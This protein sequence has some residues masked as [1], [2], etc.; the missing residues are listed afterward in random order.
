MYNLWL[1]DTDGNIRNAGKISCDDAEIAED[2]AY[3]RANFMSAVYDV[4]IINVLCEKVSK[5]S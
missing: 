5:V 1:I 3:R 2:E 4:D